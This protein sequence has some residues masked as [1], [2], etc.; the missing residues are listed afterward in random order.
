M[1]MTHAQLRGRV[2]ELMASGDLPSERPIY[3]T[4]AATLGT[5]SGRHRRPPDTCLIC[6]EPEPTVSYFWTGTLEA[7]A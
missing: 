1:A 2:R 6:A 5:R 7:A 4:G 3:G